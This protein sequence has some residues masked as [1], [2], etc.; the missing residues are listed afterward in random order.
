[1]ANWVTISS[2]ATAGGTL[3]LALATFASVRSANQ[4]ART[5]ERALQVNL[6]PLLVPSRP[7][8]PPEKMM[9][10]DRHWATIPG[11]RAG[12][13]YADGN[14][15]LAMSLRNVGSGIAVIHGWWT[16]ATWEVADAGHGAPDDFRMQ[17]RDLFIP[18]GDTSFWQGAIRDE[19]DPDYP[20]LVESIT[21]RRP[22]SIELLYGDHEGGQR[23][24]SRFGLIPR[25]DEDDPGWMC[26]VIRH[27]NLDR[28][29]P[30]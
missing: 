5:A 23:A 29:D 11:G 7:Q 26:T 9:W 1:M 13:E 14:I 3:V 27:W 19:T 18:A 25:S 24:I 22:I 10:H 12:V 16:S 2:F 17:T 30:R 21:L 20:G 28:P 6:R 4:A 15:Y 8:D